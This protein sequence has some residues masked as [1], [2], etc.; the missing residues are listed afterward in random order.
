VTLKCARPKCLGQPH[1]YGKLC[2]SWICFAQNQLVGYY[3]FGKMLGRTWFNFLIMRLPRMPCFLKLVMCNFEM[4]VS[5]SH[6]PQRD[7]ISTFI[8][9]LLQVL[10]I[11]T[12][13]SHLANVVEG[14]S[15]VKLETC[16]LL[17]VH[18]L[19]IKNSAMSF[20]GMG[21]MWVR[22]KKMT[23]H[24]KQQLR[25]AFWMKIER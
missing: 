14:P 18:W 7:V 6:Q 9:N 20:W 12:A 8:M 1:P 10:N 4:Y 2:I 13:S 11:A 15:L 5:C 16:M 21:C 17:V 23:L 19:E 24:M 25:R 3:S 22:G